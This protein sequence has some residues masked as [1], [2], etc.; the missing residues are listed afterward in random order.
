MTEKSTAKDWLSLLEHNV[1]TEQNINAIQTNNIGMVQ[2][3]K[4]GRRERQKEVD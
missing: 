2:Q 3:P 4:N 1:G